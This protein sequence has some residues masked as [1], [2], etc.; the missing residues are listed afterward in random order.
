MSAPA[1]NRRADAAAAAED[2]PAAAAD[3]HEPA[4]GEGRR[5]A[6]SSVPP[7]TVVPPV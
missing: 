5:L 6:M 2:E 7:E 4:L 3:G 1:A